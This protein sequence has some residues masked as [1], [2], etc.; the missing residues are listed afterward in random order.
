MF[1]DKILVMDNGVRVG[2]G[3]YDEF[4]KNC[5]IYKDIYRI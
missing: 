5:E 3:I 4:M 2:Y 1:V